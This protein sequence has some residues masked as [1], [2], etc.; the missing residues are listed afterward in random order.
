[1]NQPSIAHLSMASITREPSNK[2]ETVNEI[3][4]GEMA[5]ILTVRKNWALIRTEWDDYEGWIDVRQLIPINPDDAALF[6]EDFSCVL[7]MACEAAHETHFLTA[8]M[9]ASLPLFDGLNFRLGSERYTF[10]G[11]AWNGARTQPTAERLIRLARRYLYAPYRWGGRSIFGIDCSGFTQIVYKIMGVRLKRDSSQQVKQ[12][13]E[14]GF[15]EETQTGDLAFFEN[16]KGDI[17]HVGIVLPDAQIIHASGRVRIDRLDHYG[18]FND[19]RNEYSHKL[20]TIRRII[21]QFAVE[22]H[23][24]KF[25]KSEDLPVNQLSIF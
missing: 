24:T 20:R 15:V 21:P 12:G 11:R 5:D 25:L 22:N 1:M 7:D 19:E 3:L 16:E 4:F 9:G 13:Y 23:F 2:S 17:V 6:R 14:I 18:I 10:S 8:T